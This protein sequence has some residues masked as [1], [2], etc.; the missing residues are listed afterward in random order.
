MYFFH[1]I[2]K[3]GMGFIQSMRKDLLLSDLDS[4]YFRL[5]QENYKNGEHSYTRM[6]LCRIISRTP[7]PRFYCSV[8]YALR[9]IHDLKRGVNRAK[10]FYRRKQH[11]D[12][13]CRFMTLPREEQT[14][15]SLE[16]ILNSPAP[17]FYL[18]PYRI[19]T[20]LYKRLKGDGYN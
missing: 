19:N 12:L 14:R 1:Y 6:E 2:C 11:R 5:L 13:F 9:I 8:E 10:G 15:V 18:S 16:R 7:A 17:S 3:G 4:L 20:L